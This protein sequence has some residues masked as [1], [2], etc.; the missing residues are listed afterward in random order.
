MIPQPACAT[1][2]PV[3]DSQRL[4]A[5][6]DE[7]QESSRALAV[8]APIADAVRRILVL[9][10]DSGYG[11]VATARVLRDHLGAARPWRI[12]IVDVY[13]E[14]LTGLD[15]FRMLTGMS[16]PDIYN[17]Y[18]LRRGHTRVLWPMIAAGS[19]VAIRLG[20]PFVVRQLSAYLRAR[21]YD[22]VIS[23]MPLINAAVA[24]SLRQ[25]DG[26]I[27]FVTIVTDFCEPMHAAWIQ[28]DD[29]YVVC[30]TP[31]CREQAR[32]FGL[33]ETRIVE[34]KGL[35]LSPKFHALARATTPAGATASRAALGLAPDRLTGLMM[36]GGRGADRMLDFARAIE[37]SDLPVQMIYVCGTNRETANDI[38]MLPA[39]R[40][41]HVIGFSDAIERY[42][43]ASD[44]FVGKPGPGAISEAMVMGLPMILEVG[45]RLLAQERYNAN[46]ARAMGAALSFRNIDGLCAAIAQLSEPD[47]LAAMRRAVAAHPNTA[48]FD[49]P[50]LLDEIFSERR[51]A[52]SA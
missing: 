44:F 42:M 34:T 39:R 46:W 26:A 16:G 43:A 15:P 41:R 24:A 4:G 2:V 11:H 48:I 52:A 6:P 8:A 47:R 25:L 45:A 30:G 40:P 5:V 7:E 23:V 14:I 49:L 13:R 21:R 1:V 20:S 31:K 37:A 22:M 33:P 38:A 29:Q 18:A 17:E 50:A 35:V 9:Y 12:D 10:T 3:L 32:R 51:V 27:P 19:S 28:S 36:F